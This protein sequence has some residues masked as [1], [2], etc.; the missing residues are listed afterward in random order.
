MNQQPLINTQAP[1]ASLMTAAMLPES[2]YG[3]SA[4]QLPTRR[5]AN[6]TTVYPAVPN[7]APGADAAFHDHFDELD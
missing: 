1:G 6:E 2:Y 7:T 4:A 5:P 3:T